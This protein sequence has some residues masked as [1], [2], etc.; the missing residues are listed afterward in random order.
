MTEGTTEERVK[1]GRGAEGAGAREENEEAEEE[2]GRE[3]V[4][5]DEKGTE[6]GREKNPESDKGNNKDAGLKEEEV[7]GATLRTS[8]EIHHTINQN[9]AHPENVT[10][11]TPAYKGH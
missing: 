10:G 6:G 7:E 2:R 9:L 1:R 11:L 5:E 3:K 8:Q 4:G